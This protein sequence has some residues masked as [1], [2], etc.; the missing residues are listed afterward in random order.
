[1]P[2]KDADGD[3]DAPVQGE[4]GECVLEI[5]GECVANSYAEESVESEEG[6]L[7]E[8]DPQL[9][10][11]NKEEAPAKRTLEQAAGQ[12]QI[13]R[14]PCPLSEIRWASFEGETAKL[15]DCLALSAAEIDVEDE[16][17]WRPIHEAVVHAKS[18][19]VLQILIDFGADRNALTGRGYSPLALAVERNGEDH[20]T[21]EFLRN[22][23]AVE[24]YPTTGA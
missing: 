18:V 22:A 1:V 8:A 13:S 16:N 14:N 4:A 7:E 19:D 23:G 20:P 12:P 10:N 9:P 17:G 3:S 2:V 15:A 24:I 6:G 11:N 5:S 21:V